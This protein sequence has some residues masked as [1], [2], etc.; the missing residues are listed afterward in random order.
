MEKSAR[1]FPGV[2]KKFREIIQGLEKSGIP[3][4]N[5]RKPPGFDSAGGGA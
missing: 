5:P 3:D 1:F 2:W 4:S